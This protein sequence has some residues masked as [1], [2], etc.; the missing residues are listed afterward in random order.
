MEKLSN[1]ELCAEIQ[2]GKDALMGTLVLQN[3]GLVRNV[4]QRYIT[5]ARRNGGLDID[6]LMQAAR[7]G[8]I[9][10]ARQY[11]PEL[12]M[13]SSY[14]TL[15]MRRECRR[16]LCADKN[17]CAE[18]VGGILRL[19]APIG[20]DYDESI[21]DNLSPEQAGREQPSP[22]QELERKDFSRIVREAV[23]SIREPGRSA[24]KEQYFAG[25]QAA[26]KRAKEQAFTALRK[27]G[28]IRRLWDEYSDPYSYIR[29]GV[30]TFAS[31]GISS[32]EMAVIRREYIEILSAAK[33]AAQES[34]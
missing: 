28:A 12:G 3:E 8:L 14:C 30:T 7:L 29:R 9:I 20:E 25:G 27:H 15:H 32:V 6:D 1:E 17:G 22:E 10:A 13:F 18:N 24:I 16:A 4:A 5:A 26:A 19:D 11:N 23:D 31:T 21:I 33:R 34:P 2:K